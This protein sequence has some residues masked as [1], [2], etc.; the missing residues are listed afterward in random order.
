M[1]GFPDGVEQSTASLRPA[2]PAAI[3]LTGDGAL[4]MVVPE[5]VIGAV[6]ASVARMDGE[7]ARGPV[8][9]T[10]RDLQQWNK[11][12]C[13]ITVTA[14]VYQVC[15]AR[16]PREVEM[17]VSVKP[18]QDSRARGGYRLCANDVATFDS[19][20]TNLAGRTLIHT[21]VMFYR[22]CRGSTY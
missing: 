8:R 3:Q 1:S 4:S 9:V 13:C 2:P 7:M 6:K 17:I 5:G 14:D 16:A 10:N 20:R 18:Q 22:A 15:G 19:P 21:N 11:V 12:V